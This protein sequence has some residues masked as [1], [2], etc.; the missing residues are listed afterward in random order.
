MLCWPCHRHKTLR[1]AT[2]THPQTYSKQAAH[3]KALP[4][5]S[6]TTHRAKQASIAKPSAHQTHT[7][8]SS[9]DKNSTSS[10]SCKHAIQLYSS[11]LWPGPGW[12]VSML[13][14]LELQHAP[15]LAKIPFCIPTCWCMWCV[16][17][18]PARGL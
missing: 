7:V 12:E 4:Y 6:I 18:G 8:L 11:H 10:A 2:C 17:G 13:L 1:N 15:D 5:T 3:H 14:G 9:P 16:Q